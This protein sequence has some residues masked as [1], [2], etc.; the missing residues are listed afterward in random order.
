MHCAVKSK[1]I[2]LEFTVQCYHYD[3]ENWASDFA[4]MLHAVG[5]SIDLNQPIQNIFGRSNFMWHGSFSLPLLVFSMSIYTAPFASTSGTQ[6]R[7]CSRTLYLH[8]KLALATVSDGRIL[9]DYCA[10]ICR[11]ELAHRSTK[12]PGCCLTSGSVCCLVI[13]RQSVEFI[14]RVY[15]L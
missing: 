7:G 9:G 2:W 8:G 11:L 10:S 6:I 1:L 3:Q 4:C 14:P 5:P 13:S 12:S 15:C